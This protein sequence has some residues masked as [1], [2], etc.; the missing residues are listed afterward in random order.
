MAAWN[1][2]KGIE[3]KRRSAVHRHKRAIAYAVRLGEG[4]AT[5]TS[6]GR[7]EGLTRDAISLILQR[8]CPPFADPP[9]PSPPEPAFA[10]KPP[11]PE[12]RPDW[13]R[14]DPALL[15][16]ARAA[17][18]EIEAAW[19]KSKIAPTSNDDDA[20]TETMLRASH[21]EVL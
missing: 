19:G 13:T 18:A 5:M 20:W 9:P 15:A 17:R 12:K 10:P 1:G 8:A 14:P 16:L 4:T 11:K 21:P 2:P 6:I 3:A 7:E